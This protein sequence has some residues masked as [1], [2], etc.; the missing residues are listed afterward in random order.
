MT[1]NNEKL[2]IL[3]LRFNLKRQIY[4]KR[5]MNAEAALLR[6]KMAF[7]GERLEKWVLEGKYRIKYNSMDEILEELGV[8]SD[9]LNLYCSQAFNKRFLSWRKELRIEDAKRML[10]SS[11]ETPA[12]KIG[13]SLGISDKADFRHQFKSLTGL[14]PS[15]WREKFEKK[16][17]KNLEY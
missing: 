11:P 3:N 8:T 13:E 6:K 4:L 16:I 15:E 12:S 2:P 5:K 9:E 17:K 10:I 14:S 1:L 7:T